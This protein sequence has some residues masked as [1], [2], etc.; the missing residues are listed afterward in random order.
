M[1]KFSISSFSRLV[2]Y[3]TTPFLFANASVANAQQ[4]PSLVQGPSAKAAKL[5]PG[6]QYALE[7]HCSSNRNS[8]E[9]PSGPFTKRTR[10]L[11]L[12]VGPDVPSTVD[13]LPS[14]VLA[15]VQVYII[16]TDSATGAQI[17]T[18]DRD[19][20]K[21]FL[22][23]GSGN[24]GFVVTESVIDNFSN[25]AAGQLLSGALSLISPLFSLFTG[26]ALPAMIVGRITNIGAAQTASQNIL[27]VLNS[28]V[29]TTKA[30]RALQV[31]DYLINTEYARVTISIR[32]VP[33]I[34]LDNNPAFRDDLKTQINSANE[35]L[36]SSKI[37]N[38]C[39]GARFDIFSLGFKSPVDLA[40][41]LAQLSAHAGFSLKDSITCLTPEYA[42]VAAKADTV[43]FWSN[44]PGDF[45][46]KESD[47]KPP[48][49]DAGAQPSFDSIDA[50]LDDLVTSLARYARN[51]PPPD[52][53][54]S[55]LSKLLGAQV[56]VI[57]TTTSLALGGTADPVPRFEA[58]DRFKTRGY[59]RFG[60][61]A[62]TD[63]TTTDQQVDKA[64][65]MFLVFKASNDDVVTTVDNALVIRPQFLGKTVKSLAVSDNRAWI[66]ATLKNRSYEC[67]GFEVKKPP[68]AQ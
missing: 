43:H 3:F 25:S 16:G 24:P 27:N 4:R 67:N 2:I 55:E 9:D 53:A 7:I 15:A 61:Y 32:A 14:N 31:G 23:K 21:S 6:S 56:A 60:C 63:T 39:R 68:G 57:D 64:T 12:V 8:L 41:G 54:T 34:V 58:I 62:P 59:L 28:G 11:Y 18:D 50:T 44:F 26:Q 1:K 46:I 65:S 35:K 40:F 42:S 49:A 37:D 20:S 22:L 13:K 10:S 51:T 33:S 30:V 47:L 5:V 52:I 38:T 19:C 36:D 48:P 29:I 45:R 17:R 66:V